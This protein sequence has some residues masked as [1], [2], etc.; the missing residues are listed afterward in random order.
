MLQR[1]HSAILSTYIKLS[2]VIKTFV[3]SFFF[4]GRFSQVLLYLFVFLTIALSRV[5]IWPLKYNI[6]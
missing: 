6:Y 4:S 3:L 2:V 1:K 5:M